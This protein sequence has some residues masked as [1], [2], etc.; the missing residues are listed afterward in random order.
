MSECTLNT[1]PHVLFW[2][3]Y[4]RETSSILTAPLRMTVPCMPPRRATHATE[5][6]RDVR[7]GRIAKTHQHVVSLARFVVV[8]T[9]MLPL[10]K[11]IV[12]A[13]AGSH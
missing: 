6:I 7:P 8:M 11:L 5:G 13:L 4:S 1:A 3:R 12:H 9:L 10:I 2:H